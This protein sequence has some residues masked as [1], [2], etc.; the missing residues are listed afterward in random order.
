MTTEVVPGSARSRG[1]ATGFV[2]LAA[3]GSIWGTPF[4]LGKWALEELSVQHMIL[5]RFAFASLALALA[6]WHDRSR[7]AAGRARPRFTRRELGIA[8]LAGV[9]G[10]P[11]QYIVQFEGLSRTT[12]SHASLMVGVLP[13]L[14]ALAAS[15][16]AHERLDAVGWL[17]LGAST[18]GAALVAFGGGSSGSNGPT[19]LG[20]GL[21]VASLFAGVV[22]VLLSQRLMQ[23]QSSVATSAA[24]FMI[25]TGFLAV[26][27]LATHGLPPLGHLSTRTWLSVITMGVVGTAVATMLWNWGLSHIAASQAGVFV[28]LEPVV[29]AILG[30]LLFH[31]RFGVLSVVGAVLILAASIAVSMRAPA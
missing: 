8:A 24:V 6:F 1:R 9:I 26:W 18:V 31:D 15:L 25:G 13:V 4:V 16:F 30:V 29:G 14:L 27:V 11:V 17:W 20:D 19:L 10:V 21:V 23:T 7:V 12:V 28:N 3:A 5:L 2:A 22:W